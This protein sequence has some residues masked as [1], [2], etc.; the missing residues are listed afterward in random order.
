MRSGWVRWNAYSVPTTP[1]GSG[2]GEFPGDDEDYS[3]ISKSGRW[4]PDGSYDNDIVIKYCCQT[5]GKWFESIELPV[6]RPF[7]LLTS[8]ST[9]TP[10]CQMVKWAFSHMEYILFDTIDEDY[11][12]RQEGN[13]IFMKGRK[14]F[15]CYYKGT[16]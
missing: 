7:Y 14:M 6:T 11:P 3:N 10:V 8:N 16:K 1:E 15:Y 5:E 2:T 9:N 4:L 13:H 12:L